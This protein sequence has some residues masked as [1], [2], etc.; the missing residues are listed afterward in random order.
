M[1]EM[2][3]LVSNQKKVLR[4]TRLLSRLAVHLR[5]ELLKQI[6]RLPK[7]NK[8]EIKQSLQFRIT[9]KSLIVSSE[10]PEFALSFGVKPHKMTY[11]K[12]RVIPIPIEYAL[13][14][15]PRDLKHGVAFRIV[16][17]PDHPG[18]EGNNFVTKALAKA[19][20][21]LAHELVEELL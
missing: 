7:K 5:R 13:N 3:L 16:D 8:T 18:Y 4:D 12:N 19:E 11:V 17:S 10:H 2:S 9:P 6:D 20:E 14:P 1:I 15:T 21:L